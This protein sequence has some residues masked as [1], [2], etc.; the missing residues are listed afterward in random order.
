MFV[1]F[2]G[3]LMKHFRLDGIK[4]RRIDNKISKKSLNECQNIKKV[5]LTF[6][7]KKKIGSFMTEPY[8]LQITKPNK[9]SNIFM[10]SI[11][12]GKK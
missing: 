10:T 1:N 3:D 4:L 7:L 12:N 11:H 8:S 2:S 5:D 6:M 9:F